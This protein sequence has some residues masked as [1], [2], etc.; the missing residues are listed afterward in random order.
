MDHDGSVV[1]ERSS[2]T[3]HGKSVLQMRQRE[4]AH[5]L[6]LDSALHSPVKIGFPMDVSLRVNENF[7]NY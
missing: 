7:S 2:V 4:E 5:H 6:E 3:S 1:G